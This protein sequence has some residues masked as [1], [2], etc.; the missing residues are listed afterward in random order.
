MVDRD[1]VHV[2]SKQL[3]SLLYQAWVVV[4]MMMM[5]HELEDYRNDKW[6]LK[7]KYSKE[8]RLNVTLSTTNVT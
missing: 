5:I 7:R 3:L 1:W 8:T 2:V 6:Q 4:V